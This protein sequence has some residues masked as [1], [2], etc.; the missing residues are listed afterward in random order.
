MLWQGLVA[1]LIGYGTV[2]I[3]ISGADVL[4]GRSP[5]YTAALLGSAYFYGAHSL[6]EVVVAPGPV[7]AYNGTHLIVPGAGVAGGSS[8][9][10]R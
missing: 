9:P 4:A 5:L 6:A 2:A 8:G 7:F 10:S 1:G 3:V